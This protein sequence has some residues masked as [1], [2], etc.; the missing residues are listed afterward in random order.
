[1]TANSNTVT[2]TEGCIEVDNLDD[3]LASVE[4]RAFRMAQVAAG[5]R[6]AAL[7]IVQDAM[8]KLVQHYADKQASQWRPLFFRILGN[9]ITDWHRQQKSRWAVFDRWFGGDAEG[10]ESMDQFSADDR[11]E[12]LSQVLTTATLASIETAVRALSPRQQQVFML[13][14]W[15][16]MSTA[17]AAEAMDCTQGTVKTLYSRA[18]VNLRNQLETDHAG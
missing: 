17:E 10:E 3:F 8:L 14:C 4:R 1:M 7:D 15:E 12:P 11:Q 9:R 5:D 13:R 16:G 6:D 2:A 18:I